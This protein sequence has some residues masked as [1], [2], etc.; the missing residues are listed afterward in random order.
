MKI[1]QILFTL[2]FC[3]LIN[4]IPT[5]PPFL[6]AHSVDVAVKEVAQMPESAQIFVILPDLFF[7]FF[8]KTQS[9]ESISQCECTQ[10]KECSKMLTEHCQTLSQAK[11]IRKT[12]I[13]TYQLFFPEEKLSCAIKLMARKVDSQLFTTFTLF[14]PQK[15][16]PKI[17]Q[18]LINFC[19]AAIPRLS[20]IQ[21]NP[22]TSLFG[23]ISL[24]MVLGY[25]ITPS[26]PRK[27]ILNKLINGY[28][29]R[30]V[31][32]RYRYN[33]V[34]R[35][36]YPYTLT[37][38]E[39]IKLLKEHSSNSK[40]KSANQEPAQCGS[41]FSEKKTFFLSTNEDCDKHENGYC[42]DCW[43][44]ILKVSQE[45]YLILIKSDDSKT[46]LKK[47]GQKTDPDPNDQSNYKQ[48]F[49]CPICK[50]EPLQ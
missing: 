22:K 18:A 26:I 3:S 46:G 30:F 17:T 21:R 40:S 8:K 2:I 28:N 41:C 32:P 31:L 9:F 23:C 14:V 42:L 13:V 27:K 47:I 4:A 39:L 20:F 34:I 33:Q 45:E 15:N 48:D 35:T 10:T 49:R 6:G 5:Q 37:E 25:H 12:S 19:N 50:H 43:K 24:A 29:R 7:N 36:T 11:Q 16:D 38:K 1:N 44:E